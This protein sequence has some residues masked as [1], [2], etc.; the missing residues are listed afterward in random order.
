MPLFLDNFSLR[1]YN[2]FG[3]DVKAKYFAAFFELEDL[4]EILDARDPS[5][6][7]LVLG[8]GSNILFT[9]NVDGYVLKNGMSGLAK[10]AE[11]DDHV[12]VKIGAG[13]NWNRV[14]QTCVSKGWA[15]IEN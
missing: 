15:G 5:T 14:V 3:L 11:D 8:G 10:I 7:M 4:R 13:E 9:R 1:E 12:Y 6:D 2:T